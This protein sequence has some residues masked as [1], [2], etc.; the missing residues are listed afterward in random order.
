MTPA[1]GHPAQTEILKIP[2]AP[3]LDPVVAVHGFRVGVEEE[4]SGPGSTA[5]PKLVPCQWSDRQVGLANLP[6]RGPNRA[7]AEQ[8]PRLKGGLVLAGTNRGPGTPPGQEQIL[9]RETDCV[10][11]ADTQGRVRTHPPGQPPATEPGSRPLVRDEF[12]ARGASA[13]AR[14]GVAGRLV[15]P[16]LDRCSVL[17]SWCA[18]RRHG[19]GAGG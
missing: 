19:G 8:A 6:A 14:T 9:K 16:N 11:T 15:P 17:K 12:R 7:R 3:A 10:A 4:Y 2:T 5:G 13:R 18:V 1:G